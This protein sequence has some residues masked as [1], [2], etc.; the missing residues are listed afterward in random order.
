MGA[1]IDEKYG[2]RGYDLLTFTLAIEELSRVC[3]ST[4]II[5]SIHNCLYADLVQTYGS[6]DQIKEF[7][8]PFTSGQIGVF[9]LSEHGRNEKFL[10][11]I[12]SL[13]FNTI[14]FSDAG[15]D[16]ANLSTTAT[17]TESGYYILNGRKAW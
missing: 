10:L 11:I 8:V 16:A 5:V 2:G 7:L 6:S 1:C 13:F 9:A 17:K 15:S 12:G 4:G 3:A 14:L